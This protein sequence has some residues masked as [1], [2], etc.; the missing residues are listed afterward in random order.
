[1]KYNIIIYLLLI[2]SIFITIL[3]LY[4]KVNRIGIKMGASNLIGWEYKDICPL[5]D[6]GSPLIFGPLIWPA[7]HV[8]AENYPENP[9]EEYKKHCY[10]FLKGLPYMLPCP[11]CGNHLLNEET[12][13]KGQLG[14]HLD[15]NL[16]KAALSRNNLRDFLVEAHNNVNKHNNKEEWTSDKV[17]NYYKEIPAC[18][19]NDKGWFTLSEKDKHINPNK[20]DF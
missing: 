16:K 13:R 17:K 19:Y 14:D 18:I 2:Y 11:Y 1:M 3:Y 7:L 6:S 15:E 8:I 5:K 4:N 20:F 9:N 12:T 10:N